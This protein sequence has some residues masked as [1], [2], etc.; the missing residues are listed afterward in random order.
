MKIFF[1]KCFSILFNN[2]LGRAYL[3]VPKGKKIYKITKSSV[4]YYTGEISKRNGLPV[5]CTGN[6][7]PSGRLRFIK[8]LEN[9]KPIHLC[10]LFR[11][12]DWK[13]PKYL[14]G[15]DTGFESPSGNESASNWN[16]PTNSYI[17]NGSYSETWKNDTSSVVYKTYGISDLSGDTIVG[18]EVQLEGYA[19]WDTADGTIYA[20][21]SYNGGSNYTSTK[22]NLF[23]RR[24]HGPNDTFTY[25]GSDELWG[26]TW[27]GSEFSDANFRTKLLEETAGSRVLL[28]YISVKVYYTEAVT[29]TGFFQLF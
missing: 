13:I 24:D 18:I 11:L 19:D 1:N 10:W 3:G 2:P 12:L 28:D 5:I 29:D 21:L 27:S 6:C 23:V 9:W 8:W 26:R 17:L 4:H 7:S 22:S 20:S 25:G 16:N 15:D 14:I